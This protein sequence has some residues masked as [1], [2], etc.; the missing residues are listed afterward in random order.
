MKPGAFKLRVNWIQLVQ[1]HHA[2]RAAWNPSDSRR[3]GAGT[4]AGVLRC[5]AGAVAGA[6]AVMV[7]RDVRGVRGDAVVFAAAAAAVLL[8]A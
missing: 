3:P 7:V 5:A 4:D 2:K 8:F 6:I 1:P